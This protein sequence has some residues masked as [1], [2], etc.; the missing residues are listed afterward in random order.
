MT[1]TGP[2][3]AA[4]RAELAPAPDITQGIQASQEN[5]LRRQSIEKGTGEFLA[6]RASSHAQTSPQGD[7]SLTF[8]DTDLREFVKVILTD[9]LKVNYLIESRVNGRVSMQASRSLRRDE[10]FALLEDVLAMNN[11]AIIKRDSLYHI[12]NLETARRATTSPG[13]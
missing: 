5:R 11:A 10:L 1:T 6:S 7:L 2:Q 3:P 4:Q 13:A 9:L 8:E 12:V